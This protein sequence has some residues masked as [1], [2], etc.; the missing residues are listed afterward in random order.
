M[1]AFLLSSSESIS[2]KGRSIKGERM[3]ACHLPALLAARTPPREALVGRRGR[4][5][6]PSP[7]TV[8][9]ATGPLPSRPAGSLPEETSCFMKKMGSRGN[10]QMASRLKGREGSDCAAG[11]LSALP[12]YSNP[13]LRFYKHGR[14]LGALPLAPLCSLGPAGAAEGAPGALSQADQAPSSTERW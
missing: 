5:P 11:L 6:L 12:F 9:E 1:V 13:T 4:A 2:Q 14:T 10:Y 3:G 7:G 8:Y